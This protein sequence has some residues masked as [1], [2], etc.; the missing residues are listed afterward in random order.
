VAQAER[1]PINRAPSVPPPSWS[2]SPSILLL[3]TR[4]YALTLHLTFKRGLRVLL[5]SNAFCINK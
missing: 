5:I 1:T 4:S 2:Y 3:T